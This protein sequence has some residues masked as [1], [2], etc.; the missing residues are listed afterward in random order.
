MNIRKLTEEFEKALDFVDSR[1]DRIF[2]PVQLVCNTLSDFIKP[3]ADIADH[4]FEVIE[5]AFDPTD[6]RSG[7]GFDFVPHTDPELTERFVV[8]P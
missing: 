4:G 3:V 6:R 2:R 1:F 8:V 5:L 7:N